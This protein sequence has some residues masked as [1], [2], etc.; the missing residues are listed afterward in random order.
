MRRSELR[1][2]EDGTKTQ[3]FHWRAGAGAA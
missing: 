3:V 1:I 2:N